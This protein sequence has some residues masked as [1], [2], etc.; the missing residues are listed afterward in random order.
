M[1]FR[2]VFYAKPFLRSEPGVPLSQPCNPH[3]SG[4]SLGGYYWFWCV[5]SRE[6]DA[7]IKCLLELVSSGFSPYAVGSLD[8][9]V[10]VIPFASLGR[11][12]ISRFC[13]GDLVVSGTVKGFVNVPSLFSFKGLY[14]FVRKGLVG[15]VSVRLTGKGRLFVVLSGVRGLRVSELFDLGVRVVEPVRVPP[16]PPP[17][18]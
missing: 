2:C 3:C 5:F 18:I 14:G 10:F 11:G 7:F 6:E 9:N 4:F 8:G 13:S 17:F 16:D 1:M 15:G 12:F